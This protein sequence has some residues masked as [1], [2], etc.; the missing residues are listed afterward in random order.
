MSY[1]NLKEFPIKYMSPESIA[2]L[3]EYV[4]KKINNDTKN[5]PADA[6]LEG[7]PDIRDISRQVATT[8]F[9]YQSLNKAL[10]DFKIMQYKGTVSS[11]EDLT[12]ADTTIGSTYIAVQPFIYIDE[13]GKRTEISSGDMF[14]R[15]NDGW[16]VI[17]SGSVS[18][19]TSTSTTHVKDNFVAFNDETGRFVHDSGI[20]I[21]DITDLQSGLES[22]VQRATERENQIYDFSDNQ[23]KLNLERIN[24]LRNTLDEEMAARESGD[25]DVKS[26][27]NLKL[28]DFT[29]TSFEGKTVSQ[30]LTDIDTKFTDKIGEIDSASVAES[31]KKINDI[32]GTSSG[33][34]DTLISKLDNEIQR[35]KDAEKSLDNKISSEEKRALAEEKSIRDYLSNDD[36]NGVIDLLQLSDIDMN[37]KIS[38]LKNSSESKDS[39]ILE[40]LNNF[41]SESEATYE[42]KT[43]STLKFNTLKTDLSDAVQNLK[44]TAFEVVYGVKIEEKKIVVSISDMLVKDIDP[45]DGVIYLV[46]SEREEYLGGLGLSGSYVEYIKAKSTD[47]FTIE[48]IGS[49]TSDLYNYYS[50]GEI[51]TIINGLPIKVIE[52]FPPEGIE[53]ILYIR[54]DSTLWMWAQDEGK[55]YYEF[56]QL[57]AKDKELRARVETL[58]GSIGSFSDAVTNDT[59][60][61]LID[62]VVV[63]IDKDEET[64]EEVPKLADAKIVSLSSLSNTLVAYEAWFRRNEDTKIVDYIDNELVKKVNIEDIIDNLTSISEETK[65]LSAAQGAVLNSRIS[66]IKESVDNSISSIGTVF[67]F[68]GSV[69]SMEELPQNTDESL[70]NYDIN[71]K[72]GDAYEVRPYVYEITTNDIVVGVTDVSHYYIKDGENYVQ[73]SGLAEDGTTYYVQTKSSTSYGIYAYTED[74]SADPKVCRWV[75]IG[76]EFANVLDYVSSPSDAIDMIDS[77]TD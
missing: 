1:N 50:K 51:D 30:S 23:T 41:K 74:T 72:V 53:N 10:S 33:S 58:A 48:R 42:T 7:T 77:Y 13:D 56:V 70:D 12:N 49:I 14:I 22:E 5:L 43:D 15:G 32:I 19:I 60:K 31:I 44:S 36:S 38:E 47:G 34:G 24:S 67:K 46:P 39:E 16:D 2:V 26:Y 17:V 65:P 63:V 21:K 52:S 40:S 25:N 68:K 37:N 66:E 3:W 29:G 76:S 45:E 6:R 71:L 55:D 35:A 75:Q 62:S 9:V 8:E 27:I 59:I 28:G 11:M 20:S 61:N 4:K 64:G 69:S 54:T 18:N 73:A 57:G